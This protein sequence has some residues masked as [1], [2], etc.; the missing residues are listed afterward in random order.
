MQV[1]CGTTVRLIDK[2]FSKKPYLKESC[3]KGDETPFQGRASAEMEALPDYDVDTTVSKEYYQERQ[4][5]ERNRQREAELG[6]TGWRA[7]GID[8]SD[9]DPR[10][11]RR[12]VLTASRL[13]VWLSRS[14]TTL[15]F[16]YSGH[17]AHSWDEFN[18]AVEGNITASV[19]NTAGFLCGVL[20]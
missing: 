13:N 19:C 5:F 10:T 7:L 11:H 15:Y 2:I 18:P 14:D 12:Y 6:F 9:A 4:I 17:T 1:P 16:V 20:F 3:L 8:V